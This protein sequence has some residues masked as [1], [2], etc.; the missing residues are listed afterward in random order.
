MQN[1]A[2]DVILDSL[3]AHECPNRMYHVSAYP[4]PGRELCAACGKRYVRKPGTIKF[5]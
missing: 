3:A 5:E 1:K 2:I 4:G